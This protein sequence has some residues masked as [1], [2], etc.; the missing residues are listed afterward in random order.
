MLKKRLY[1]IVLVLVL[2]LG[3]F[4][5]A[6]TADGEAPVLTVLHTNDVHGAFSP[7]N[8][9][10]GGKSGAIGHDII[11]GIYGA[12]KAERDGAVMLFDA[13]DATQGVYFVG[14]SRGEAAIDIMNAAGYDA[15]VLGN[16]EF[17]YGFERLHELAGLATFPMLT[18]ETIAQ[19]SVNFSMYAMFKR[20]GYNIGVFGL[21]TPETE[22]KSAGGIELSK[23][24]TN[25][26]P[27]KELLDYAQRA[28]NALAADG[29]DYIICL[30]HLGV[31]DIGFGTSYELRDSVSGIDAIID[32]HSHTVLENI[33]QREGAAPITS[34]GSGGANLGVLEFHADGSIKLSSITAADAADYT[35]ASAVTKVINDWYDKV[36]SEGSKVVASIPEDIFLDRAN[37][38]TRESV[39][40]NIVAEAMLAASGA[41]FALENGGGIR[42][43]NSVLPAGDVTIEQLVTILPFGNVLQTAEVKGSVIKE[44]LELG[45]S[46]YPTLSGGFPQIAGVRFT[47]NPALSAGNRITSITIG[48][49]ELDLN[50]TYK[51]ATNDFT[52]AGG[53]NYKM[54]AE[55]FKTQLPLAMPERAALEQALIGYL[56]DNKGKLMTETDGRITVRWSFSDLDAE[57]DAIVSA[58]ADRGIINGM[59]D[60]IFAP[61]QSL[62]RAQMATMLVRLL[63]LPATPD[64]P[65]FK[66]MTGD[67]WYADYVL[68]CTAAELIKGY[69]DGTFG[70]NKTLTVAQLNV[71]VAR[72]TAPDAQI[73]HDSGVAA[74]RMQAAEA[75]FEHLFPVPLSC[76]TAD[77]DAGVDDAAA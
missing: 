77:M 75:L 49:E 55:P 22:F 47:F 48:G 76:A 30:S 29:A 44:A 6:A 19:K 60:G 68:R 14:Q 3:M 36:K 51:M 52:A 46:A 8:S 64:A 57:Q 69:D 16:H 70:G 5:V 26:G 59:G 50:K 71:L 53:D 17:D 27:V 23:E 12:M 21:T 11:A 7:V 4:S 42:D 35:P 18:Q 20:G 66:D 24:G 40:G 34:T 65:L 45:V 61:D 56:N 41:D 63:D 10:T 33:V 31:E 38:R 13:G 72:I 2:A 37:E 54:L 25:F 58:L 39:I 67:E 9:L 43:T 1:S 73:E 62:T 28:V 74:T 32:G 15:M